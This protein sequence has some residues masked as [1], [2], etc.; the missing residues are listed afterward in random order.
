[1]HRRFEKFS[2]T[3]TWRVRLSEALWQEAG[4]VARRYG[5]NVVAHECIWIIQN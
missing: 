5:V 4:K 3:Q 1:V 2:G